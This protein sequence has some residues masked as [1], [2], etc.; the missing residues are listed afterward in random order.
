M[1]QEYANRETPE[2][3]DERM[4]LMSVFNDIER[5]KEGNTENWLVNAREVTAMATQLKPGNSCS[6]KPHFRKYVVE[7]K[8]QRTS[9]MMS[10]GHI[11]HG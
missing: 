2:F 1:I 7:R 6:L 4:I 11:A 10:Y 8:F 3:I 9:R 5:R